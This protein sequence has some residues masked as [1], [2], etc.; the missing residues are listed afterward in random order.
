MIAMDML[1]I[2]N[3]VAWTYFVIILRGL[4]THKEMRVM[5]DRIKKLEER[6][7]RRIG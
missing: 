7:T 4:A 1:A 6:L 2:W 3:F 5:E